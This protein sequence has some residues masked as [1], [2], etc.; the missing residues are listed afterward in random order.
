MTI[1]KIAVPLAAVIVFLSCTLTKQGSKKVLNEQKESS[2]KKDASVPDSGKKAI[3][4]YNEV[5]NEKAVSRSGLFT[6][7]K[8]NDRF[9]FEI[10]GALMERDILLVN[11]VSKSPAGIRP[12]YGRFA[13]YPGDQIGEAVLRFSKGPGLKIYVKKISYVD[14]ANDSTANGLYHSVLN[15][16]LQPIVA[17]FDIKAYST[18]SASVID[19]TDY[20]NAD[21]NIFSFDA[22]A[23]KK[24]NNMGGLQTDKSYIQSVKPFPLNV[25]IKTI[26]TYE[27]LGQFVTY[28]LN[29]SIVLLPAELM[30]ARAYDNRIG[31]FAKDYKDFDHPQNPK[32][33]YMINRWRLE[34]REEDK[35]RYQRGELVEPQKPIVFYI[36][37]STPKKW[38]P[39]LIGG[40]NA[41]QKAFEKA[42]FKNAI[43]AKE[44]SLTD[45][46]WSLQDARHSV[47]V[48]KP[49]FVQNASGPQVSDPRTGEI[50]ESHI[51]WYHNV[52]K[53]LHDWYMI[54]ASPN[55]PKA[56]TMNFDDSLM[57]QLIRYVCTHE[58]G[59]TLGLQHNFIASATVPTDSLRSK[60]YVTKYGHTPSIMDYA[61]F[62]YVA[63]PEDRIDVKDLMP[64]IGV[65]D[66]WAIEWG[67]RWFSE[68]RSKEEDKAF[69]NQWIIERL[70][71]DNRLLYASTEFSDCRIQAEDLG[72]DPI[73]SGIYGIKNLQRVTSNLIEWTK[74]PNENYDDL[75]EMRTQVFDQYMRYLNNVEALIGGVYWTPKTVE[76][77]GPVLSYVS[78]AQQRAA[79]KFFQEQL[80]DAPEWLNN[81]RIFSRVGGPGVF[82]YDKMQEYWLFMIMGD[83]EKYFLSVF[84]ES[85]ADKDS[86]YT[87]DELLTDLE[88]GIWKELR[89]H[90]PI[91]FPRRNLQ[92]TYVSKLI[93]IV[94]IQKI[95][96]FGRTDGAAIAQEHIRALCKKI[97]KEISVFSDRDSRMHLQDVVSRLKVAIYHQERD[98][99]EKDPYNILSQLPNPN[100]LQGGIISPDT[101][102][103][104]LGKISDNN[105]WTNEFNW[106][107]ADYR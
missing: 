77:G 99:P 20:L 6:V 53:I 100:A 101:R 36:D 49:S 70:Q 95:A 33:G 30:K 67:Y 50:L 94:R 18:D 51:N 78:R 106:L 65:Y 58:V 86:A 81:K 84:N 7:H 79:V 74:T 9:Y 59:H 83:P 71:K 96:L 25:E 5:I 10:P 31:Y 56:R 66:E 39:Y 63:Q 88:T 104:A 68:S 102:K 27:M 89:S 1:P 28:E 62:N 107:N 41:W 52:Q 103:R 15:S 16:S 57:G 98:Y 8:V 12:N 44:V 4:P 75:T 69:M 72:D 42:G 48:Y 45:S 43:Y 46:N 22:A 40:V 87:Y 91:I 85:N 80:F 90:K 64:R 11:R 24:I 61:R 55:D 92:K 97:E 47:I 21:N 17:G 38:V 3:R 73:M 35:A 29:S 14:F 2:L 54:Q 23:K 60:S 32:K 13:S 26:R 105:C 37:P 34:P 82:V 76:Q 19:V 93:D